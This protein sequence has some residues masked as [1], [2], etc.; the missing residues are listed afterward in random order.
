MA[1][2]IRN[3]GLLQTAVLSA[4]PV[5]LEVRT[6]LGAV[7]QVTV[8]GDG[9]LIGRGDFCDLQLDDASQPLVHSE[10]HLQGH[11]VGIEA[12]D[13]NDAVIVNGDRCRRMALHDGDR[14]QCG[15]TE[16]T[17]HIGTHAETAEALALP[18]MS[19]DLTL[20]SVDELCDRIAHEEAEVAAFERGQLTGWRSLLQS[21]EATLLDDGLS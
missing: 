4:V 9:F 8:D 11:T 3:S 18:A 16:I 6:T 13:D 12:A 7:H 19:E 10:L 5:V 2:A 15:G 14:V 20:L 17:I 1:D 21:V